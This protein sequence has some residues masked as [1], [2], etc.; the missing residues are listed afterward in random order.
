MPVKIK[1]NFFAAN[2]GQVLA[3]TLECYDI[4]DQC[5]LLV[6]P[7]RACARGLQ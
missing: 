3:Y 7:H 5:Y 2:T 6:N 1:L 4:L